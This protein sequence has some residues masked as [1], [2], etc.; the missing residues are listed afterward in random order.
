MGLS[1]HKTVSICIQWLI[2]NATGPEEIKGLTERISIRKYSLEFVNNQFS[3]HVIQAIVEASLK[4]LSR[5]CTLEAFEQRHYKWSLNYILDVAEFL[6]VHIDQI[7]NDLNG[8][9]VASTVMEALAGIRVG[10]LH[11][12]RKAMGFGQKTNI[13]T[14]I[15]KDIVIKDLPSPLKSKLKKLAKAIVDRDD[16]ELREMINGK[17]T[18]IIQYLLFILKLRSA[19]LC[20]QLVKKMID[21][22]F[23]NQEDKVSVISNANCAYLVETLILV[24]NEHRLKRIW[25]KHFKGSLRAMWSHDVANF[26]VQRLLD[27]LT[28]EELY[29]DV[30][31]EILPHLASIFLLNRPGIGVCLAKATLRFTHFQQEFIYAIMKAF[32]CLEPKEKQIQLVPLMLFSDNTIITPTPNPNSLKEDKHSAQIWLHGS[33]MLQYMF[34]YKETYRLWKSLLSIDTRELVGVINDASGSHAIDAFLK[35]PTVPDKAKEQF[36]DKLGGYFVDLACNKY[37]SRVIG[38]RSLLFLPA[39]SS[40]A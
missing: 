39:A 7:L 9:H 33:L 2:E 12:N 35:S 40:E 29:R 27:S 1:F 15:E 23:C 14:E 19:E 21:L 34:Q 22:I 18:S 31:F 8:F 17:A 38:E 25:E 4:V 5:E 26:I 36:V 3:S 6:I 11:K 20:Q 13:N 10:R 30:S 24:S 16:G 28:S 32:Y 37:G